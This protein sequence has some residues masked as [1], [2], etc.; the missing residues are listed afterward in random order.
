MFVK[1]VLLIK[2]LPKESNSTSSSRTADKVKKE[3]FPASI[4]NSEYADFFQR[5]YTADRDV[6]RS[7]GRLFFGEKKQEVAAET[8]TRAVH[9]II[10]TSIKIYK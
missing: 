8:N 1:A 9:E 6:D 3:N 7:K 4:V 10:L 5:L 2:K